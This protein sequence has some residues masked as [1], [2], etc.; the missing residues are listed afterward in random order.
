MR[1]QHDIPLAH[2]VEERAL[3]QVRVVL[4]LVGRYVAYD[5]QR[6]PQQGH[7]KVGHADRARLA[8]LAQLGKLSEGPLQ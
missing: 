2:Q 7:R 1:D 4:D 6:L 8:L 5:L 3:V